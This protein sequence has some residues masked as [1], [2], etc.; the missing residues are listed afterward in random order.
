MVDKYLY[1]SAASNTRNPSLL[2]LWLYISDF[3]TF[4]PHVFLT[5]ARQFHFL[6][7]CTSYGVPVVFNYYW[8]FGGRFFLSLSLVPHLPTLHLHSGSI[9]TSQRVRCWQEWEKSCST[10]PAAAA[11]SH[12]LCRSEAPE[13]RTGLRQ[14]STQ[15][16][17]PLQHF[18][19]RG[20]LLRLQEAVFVDGQLG[21]QVRQRWH[22]SVGRNSPEEE[23]KE[24]T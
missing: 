5:S 9:V 3:L 14:G 12:I 20:A 13:D 7:P 16:N 21:Q 8:S 19:R 15:E 1:S 4:K 18:T 23:G 2:H 6:S 11:S 22:A 10:W 17:V 24:R